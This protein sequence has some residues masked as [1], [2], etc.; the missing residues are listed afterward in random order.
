[1][2]SRVCNKPINLTQQRHKRDSDAGMFLFAL[3]LFLASFST[4]A[5]KPLSAVADPRYGVVLYEY[6]QSNHFAA[7]SEL[8]VAEQKGGIQGHKDN[9]KLMRGSLTLALGLDKQAGI[10]YSDLLDANKPLE[11]K[12]TA[13]FYLSKIRYQRGEYESVNATLAKI[14]SPISTDLLADVAAMRIQLLLKQNKVVEAEALLAE[15]SAISRIRKAFDRWRPYLNFNVATAYI[16]INERDRAA[17]FLE[18]VIVAPISKNVNFQLEQLALYDRAYLASA[19]SFFQNQ[20]Y[21]KAV[22][23]FGRVRQSAAFSN[24]ALLGLGWAEARLGNFEAALVPWSV[25]GRRTL[26]DESVQESLIAAPFAYLQLG[27]SDKAIERYTAAESIF[28]EQLV[29]LENVATQIQNESIIDILQLDESDTRYSW[30]QPEKNSLVASPSEYLSSLFALNRLQ[31]PVQTLSDLLKMKRRLEQWQENLVAYTDLLNYRSATFRNQKKPE[32]YG[33]MTAELKK[34][35]LKKDELIA[36]LDEAKSKNNVFML[37]DEARQDLLELVESGESN[38]EF[39]SKNDELINEEALWIK[40]YRGLL[41]WSASQDFAERLWRV[42]TQINEIKEVLAFARSSTQ[43]I[44]NLLINEPDIV[45]SLAKI[46]KYSA[47]V[48]TQL[49]N[50]QQVMASLENDI[51]SQIFATLSERRGRVQFYLAQTRLAVA[52]LYDQ[53]YLKRPQE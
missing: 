10:I 4:L 26:T 24:D 20:E 9:P 35:E 53:Q 17:L 36:L 8:M 39:L 1:M 2:I 51:R 37:L 47:R 48:N 27:D 29:M 19:F 18:K 16:R 13:W 6:Y 3:T 49:A 28:T 31:N 52:Q 14:I 45:G 15:T 40:R 22:D 21:Q 25:L 32:G 23:N 43:A 33:V 41:L 50:N 5:E 44:D 11:V 42:E 7:L 34:L 12:N 38:L 30:L 46:A